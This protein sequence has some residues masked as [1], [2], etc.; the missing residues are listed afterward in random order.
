VSVVCDSTTEDLWTIGKDCGLE[1]MLEQMARVGVD[2]L[3]VTHERHVVGLITFKD[4]KR[5][6]GTRSNANRVAD[7]MTDA[8]HVPM[9]DWPTIIGATVNDL[10]RLLERTHANHL[11]VVEAESSSFSRVRGLVYRRQLVQ[12]LGVFAILDRGMKSALSH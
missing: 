12:R 1:E 8:G 7:I 9:I 6:R 2:A 5:K 4:I 11:V 10:L 3:L